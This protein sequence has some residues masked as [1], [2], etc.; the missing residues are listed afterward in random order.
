MANPPP[1]HHARGRRDE[2]GVAGA[3]AGDGDDSVGAPVAIA[4][5]LDD[6]AGSG[7]V[8]FNVALIV[9][10]GPDSARATGDASFVG[11]ALPTVADLVRS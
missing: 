1:I 9:A 3:C 8:G 7:T 11:A 5:S 2:R 6:A 4:T 10:T